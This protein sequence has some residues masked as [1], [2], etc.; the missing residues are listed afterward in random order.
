MSIKLTIVTSVYNEEAVLY[1]FHNELLKK[2]KIIKVEFEIIYVNDGSSDNSETIINEL[3]LNNQFTK[4]IHLSRNFGHE[5]AMI[6]GIDRAIGDVIICMDSDLQH[7]PSLIA[8][9]LQKHKEGF[10][11]VTMSGVSRNDASLWKKLTTKLF[12]KLLNGITPF[13]FEPRAS[14]FFLISKKIANVLRGNF[15]EQARFL[16]GFIQV[17]GFRRTTIE[18]NVPSRKGGTSKY[19]FFKLLIVSINAVVSF[20]KL[21]LRLGIV[22]GMFFGVCSMAVGIYS[23]IMYFLKDPVSGYT[24]LVVLNSFL[25]SILFMLIGIAGEYMGYLFDEMKKR[26]LYIIDNEKNFNET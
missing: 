17:I 10:D 8:K 11:I 21:P 2:L 24:T 3:C 9:M 13:Y 20:S 18:F 4:A 12:Y 15:R 26:P 23:I 25:F 5:A 7:P 19:S 16:R 1:N 6:A 14:D 22:M